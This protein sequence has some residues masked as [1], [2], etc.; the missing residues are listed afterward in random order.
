MQSRLTY[1]SMHDSH[2]HSIR[3]LIQSGNNVVW[4]GHHVER[5]CAVRL[6]MQALSHTSSR[7]PI[8]CSNLAFFPTLTQR[9]RLG[10]NFQ[11]L[12]VNAP[13]V[14]VANFQ[15]DGF[16]TL[17]SQGARPNYQSSILTLSYNGKKGA[18]EGS[19]RN[20]ERE[21]RP[22]WQWKLVYKPL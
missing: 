22:P 5:W 10:V 21:A 16:S 18:L 8:Q 6:S 20:W 4:V 15:R 13:I 1:P 17:N 11:Q 14:K 19:A 9:Y 3:T 12:A 7:P 2:L